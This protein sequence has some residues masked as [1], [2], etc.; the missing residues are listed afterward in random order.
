MEELAQWLHVTEEV[1]YRGGI[2]VPGRIK[3]S[4]GRTRWVKAD[5]LA[6]LESLRTQGI[7]LPEHNGDKQEDALMDLLAAKKEPLAVV[8]IQPEPEP[9]EAKSDMF[10]I[11]PLFESEK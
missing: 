7:E 3:I 2:Q 8:G 5:V 10:Y 4:R 9:E 1:L 11:G 6:W